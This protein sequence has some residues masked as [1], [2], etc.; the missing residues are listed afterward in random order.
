[1]MAGSHRVSIGVSEAAARILEAQGVAHA[2]EGVWTP[3]D[4]ERAGAWDLLVELVTRVSIVPLHPDS[5]FMSEALSSLHALFDAG[6]SALQRHGPAVAQQRR[7]ELSLATIVAYL[8]NRVL[9]PVLADWHPIVEQHEK[10][11]GPEWDV[12]SASL[13]EILGAL[14]GL[15]AEYAKELAHACDAD[16]FVRFLL[17]EG[18][19]YRR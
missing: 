17:D 9:R 14:Q 6:R 19:H 10:A 5:G 11:G 4:A 8:L 13:R 16:E 2:L 18:M 15:I 3:N 7:G 12:L 1:M